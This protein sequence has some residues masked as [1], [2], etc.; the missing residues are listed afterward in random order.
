M[1]PSL[2]ACHAVFRAETLSRQPFPWYPPLKLLHIGK[3]ITTENTADYSVLP[4]ALYDR[5]HFI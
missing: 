1:K 4:V 5:S 2:P 3:N